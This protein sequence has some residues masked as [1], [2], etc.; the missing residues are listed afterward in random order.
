MPRLKLTIAYVGTKYSGWQRQSHNGIEL[1]TI[2][3]IVENEI[4]RICNTK[5]YLQG[6]GRTDAGVHADCQ[7]THCDIPENKISLNWQLALNTCLPHDIRIKNYAIVPSTFH[8]MFDV[9]KKSYTYSLWLNRQFVP[10]KLY[11]FTWPCGEL[12]IT[13]IDQ[14]IPY[15]IGT[16]DFAFVQNQG[17]ELKSTERTMYTILRSDYENQHTINPDNYELTLTFTANG[18]LKQMVRNLV[19]L[20]VACGKE[21]IIPQSIPDLMATKDRKKSPPTAPPQ[22]LTMS[23]IWY[24]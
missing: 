20:L 14:A 22:G 13:K 24:K 17:T 3:G 15:L 5:I 11:P 19:G 12:N 8:A 7:T 4:S 23:Q 6:S 10:P 21:K 1:P 18:F 9:E 16:H 2:Q